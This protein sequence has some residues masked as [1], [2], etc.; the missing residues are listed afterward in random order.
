MDR[1]KQNG[2]GMFVD[3]R[4]NNAALARRAAGVRM[5]VWDAHSS[6]IRRAG[7]RRSVR[8]FAVDGWWLVPVGYVC[9]LMVGGYLVV[10]VR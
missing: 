4:Q 7:R 6:D 5:P 10:D 3:Q 2:N 9:W 1:H 8:A